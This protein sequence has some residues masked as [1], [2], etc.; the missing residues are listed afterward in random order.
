MCL[1][2]TRNNAFVKF[3]AT[4]IRLRA[5]FPDYPIKSIPMDN[6]SDFTSKAFDDYCIT[7]G[8]KVEH[9][10]LTSTPKMV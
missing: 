3:I 1:L 2:S 8:I 7:L 9:P 4:F 6:V 5:Q 10:I